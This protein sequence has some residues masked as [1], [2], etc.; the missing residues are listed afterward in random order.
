MSDT[1]KVY[2]LRAGTV[3]AHYESVAA[4]VVHGALLEFVP[5]GR[6]LLAL[7]IGVGSGRDAA[8][9]ASLGYGVVASEPVVGMRAEAQRMHPNP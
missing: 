5:R 4:D 8:W 1:V 2:D 3:A 6:D 7:D 9:L